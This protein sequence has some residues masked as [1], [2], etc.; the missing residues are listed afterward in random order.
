MEAG[1]NHEG[2]LTKAFE[3]IDAAAECGAPMIKF[4]SYKAERLAQKVSPAYWDTREETCQS[5]YELFQRY[6]ALDVE[7]YIAMAERCHSKGIMFCT[8][9]FDHDFLSNLASRMPILKIASADITNIPLLRQTGKQG[10]PV[11]LST[12]ASSVA[13]IDQAIKV[14][15]SAGAPQVVLMH[16]ILEYP[17]QTHHANLRS[18]PY[19]AAVFPDHTIGWSDHLP[20][21]FAG[22]SLVSAWQLGA[23]VLEK[24]F[25]LDKSKPGNDHYHAMDPDDV[26]AFYEHVRYTGQL[27]G[28]FRKEV[29]PWERRSEQQARRSLV[30]AKD[31]KAGEVLTEQMLIPKRPGN[32]I[33][34]IYYDLL[35]GRTLQKNVPCDTA[36][37]WNDFL[38]KVL[39]MEPSDACPNQTSATSSTSPT[40]GVDD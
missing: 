7:D 16:C 18:I 36:L 39:P 11:I 10:L 2:S 25:T 12:G 34:P 31:L 5:Q 33:S 22:Q 20:F 17:T 15:E 37:D 3:M 29:F 1:V 35:I 23:D 30:A 28:D 8:T 38:G 26:R 40:C 9:A 14:L 21:Q 24:H 6:D 4:Q 19:L 13:E 27:L 32:G